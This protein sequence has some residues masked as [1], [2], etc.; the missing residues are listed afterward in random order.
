MAKQ[1]DSKI[2]VQEIISA[3]ENSV[4]FVEGMTFEQFLKDIKNSICCSTSN[5]NFRRGG[6][7]TPTTSRI[8]FLIFLGK[9]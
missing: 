8:N 3:C 4:Q 5:S 2:T 7:E 9:I 1:R 6:K